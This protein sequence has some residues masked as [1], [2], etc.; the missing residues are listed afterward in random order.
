MYRISP[1]VLFLFVR[2]IGVR[3]IFS[4]VL[5]SGFATSLPSKYSG[6][7]LTLKI[8][9]GRLQSSMLVSLDCHCSKF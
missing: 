9:W 4:Y 3:I 8:W 6:Q 2:I 5:V 7:L 1:R